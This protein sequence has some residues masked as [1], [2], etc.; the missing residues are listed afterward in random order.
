VE[1]DMIGRKKIAKFKRWSV[2][3]L[4]EAFL[5]CELHGKVFKFPIFGG[6]G[7]GVEKSPLTRLALELPLFQQDQ[8]LSLNK[9]PPASGRYRYIPLAKF[10][11]LKRTLFSW[12][13]DAC[14]AQD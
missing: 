5:F 14:P 3:F 2:C 9:S 4:R 1:G 8:L 12:C 10:L 6:V 13:S 11:A 7:S